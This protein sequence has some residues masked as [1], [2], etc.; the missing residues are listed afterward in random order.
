[1][2]AEA[3]ANRLWL[4]Q[5]LVSP[6]HPLTARVTVNRMWQELF[7]TGIVKTSEDFGTQ[8]EPPS[9]PELLDWLAAEFVES[10]WD[11]KSLYRKMMLSAT[12]RQSSTVRPELKRDP[13]NRLLARGPRFRLDAETIR[14][15]ALFVS[16]LLVDQVGGPSVKPYQPAGLWEAVG[17]TGSNTVEFHQDH[18]EA[19][20][21]RSLYTFWKRT[22]HPPNMAAFD[23]PNRESCTVRRERTNTPLQALVLMNDPHFVKASRQLAE[24]VLMEE[25]RLPLDRIFRLAVG[26]PASDGEEGIVAASLE[27]FRGAYTMDEAAARA[28]RFGGIE[29]HREGRSFRARGLDDA[30]QP[31]PEPGRSDQQELKR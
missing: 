31:A 28:R 9:H 30:G 1:M 25:N 2:P 18:G 21:R 3:P 26:R 6:A 8:G 22:S 29:L 12:Y 24:R 5:W 23:A 4:A 10:G 15:Q 11:V 19:L 17:Y 13:Q 20:Y 16:G 7:G 27:A 14:D